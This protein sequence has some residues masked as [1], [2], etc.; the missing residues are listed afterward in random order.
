M[1]EL[2]LRTLIVDDHN[3]FR[4]ALVS[5]LKTR[6]DVVTVVGE[7]AESCGA[8]KLAHE[9]RPDLILLDVLM[10]GCGGTKTAR[11]LR[12]IMPGTKIIM[13]SASSDMEH[14]REA[15][16]A[17]VDGYLTK[18]LSAKML[19]VLLQEAANDQIVITPDVAAQ[20]FKHVASTIEPAPAP[21]IP[22][23]R[24]GP[25]DT[26]IS[27]MVADGATNTEIARELGISPHTVRSHLSTILRVLNLE[28]RTQL[29]V[30]I[31]AQQP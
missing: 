9:L 3:M 4:Q 22:A 19:F 21:D 14:I 13:L 7:A 27:R 29:A 5:L 10:P 23:D 16:A 11:D 18:N 17:G 20:L 1:P 28:N 30:Y 25:L 2:P 12:A 26:A 15:I 24:L 31:K 8:L 6:P